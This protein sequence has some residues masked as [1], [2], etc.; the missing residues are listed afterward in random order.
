MLARVSMPLPLQAQLVFEFIT[1]LRGLDW[2]FAT[3]TRLPVSENGLTLSITIAIDSND[4]P[5]FLPLNRLQVN[6]SSVC[7]S[8]LK[9]DELRL[10]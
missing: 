8:I 3:N 4:W 7:S 2:I 9:M 5:V 1:C 10:A 6:N